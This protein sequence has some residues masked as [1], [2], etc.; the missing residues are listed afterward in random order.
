MSTYYN[1]WKSL[2]RFENCVYQ[3]YTR[4]FAKMYH[5]IQKIQGKVDMSGIKHVMWIPQGNWIPQWIQS[6][7]LFLLSNLFICISFWSS[8]TKYNL[9]FFLIFVD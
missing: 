7:F 9:D 5:S 6:I 4:R 2:Q 8:C 1:G 3:V